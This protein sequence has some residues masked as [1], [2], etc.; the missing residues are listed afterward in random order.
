MSLRKTLL[1][2]TLALLLQAPPTLAAPNDQAMAPSGKPEQALYWQGHESLKDGRWEEAL[3]RFKQLEE[4]LQRSEPQAAD[5][6][7]YWQAYA[8]SKARRGAEARALVER[9]RSSYP[10]SRWLGE[11]DRL[12]RRDSGEASLV[13]AALDGL[14]AAPPERALPLLKKVLDGDHPPRTK[15]RALFVLSQLDSAEASAAVLGIARRKDDP[16]QRE[17]IQ[18][19]GISGGTKALAALESLYVDSDEAARRAVLDA[20]MIAAHLPGLEQA[21]RDAG[22]PEL[23]RHAIRLLGA[24]GADRV[25]EQLLDARG[26]DAMQKA[27]LQS[28][29]VSGNRPALARFA[30]GDAPDALRIEALRAIGISGGGE[31]LARLYPGL[32]SASLRRAALEGM[33]IA[34]DSAPMRD[35][36]RQARSDEEKR[37]ILRTMTLMG[38]D[39]ALELI[40]RA[41]DEGA[42]K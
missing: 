33:L 24:M 31:D 38:D 18:M 37:D 17:A 19:L 2:A 28:L 6:A 22:H 29:G 14:L 39:G 36:Y 12:T 8:L 21:A 25:L 27:V 15:K 9:L 20:F 42:R 35:L 26:N 4:Q 5:A 30:Q 1:S 34:G 3:A 23:Q 40:E 41:I 11:A 7:L 16:L 32:R 13:D 10:D